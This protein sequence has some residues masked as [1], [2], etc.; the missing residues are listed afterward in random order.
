MEGMIAAA[1]NTSAYITNSFCLAVNME[2]QSVCS[3][4]ITIGRDVY[5]VLWGCAGPLSCALIRKEDKMGKLVLVHVVQES[6]GRLGDSF[7][8]LS[9]FK[10]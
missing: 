5:G 10:P 3:Y 2:W 7:F 9:V 4:K 1:F 6:Y 8:L